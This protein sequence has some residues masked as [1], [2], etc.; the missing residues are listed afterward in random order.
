MP[1]LVQCAKGFSIAAA[2]ALVA[3]AGLDSIPGLGTSICPAVAA[4]KKKEFY[5]DRPSVHA[6]FTVFKELS[7][8]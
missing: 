2:M 5:N 4:I 3:A 8:T 6:T 7:F 1:H